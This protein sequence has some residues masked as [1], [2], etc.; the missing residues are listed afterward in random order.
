LFAQCPDL[1]AQVE[2]MERTVRSQVEE[3]S[4]EL[5]I[6]TVN[7]VGIY[8]LPEALALFTRRFPMVHPTTRFEH[9]DVVMDLLDSG[10]I[11]VA[12]TAQAHK[13]QNGLS[14]L[15]ADDPLVLACSREH[16]LARR[17]YVRPRDLDGEKLI[18]FDERSP[19]AKL[20][21][22]TLARHDVHMDVITRTPQI[23]AMIRMVRMN[24]G[25]AFLPQLA[26][27]FE[28][29]SGALATI[30]FAVEDLHRAIWVTWTSEES[31]PARTALIDCLHEA[32]QAKVR[33][34]A[35]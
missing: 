5:R 18:A 8:L 7:S 12:L 28:T 34:A 19:T 6:A 27:T 3:P 26:M 1:F 17:H 22:A 2:A 24:M 10:E 21:D 13:P 11:D 4:G 15:L 23:A 33:P 31:L 16:P 32:A 20:I 29:E 35:L 25:L 14:R 30:D 9:A